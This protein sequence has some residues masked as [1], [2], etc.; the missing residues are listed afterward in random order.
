MLLMKILIKDYCKVLMKSCQNYRVQVLDP[1]HDAHGH[2]P[3]VCRRLGAGVQ[4]GAEALAYLLDAR[5]QLVSL[6]EYDE[7]RLVHLV[8]LRKKGCISLTFLRESEPNIGVLTSRT[9]V[10]KVR[11]DDLV[12]AGQSGNYLEAYV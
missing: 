6:E 12:K 1:G 8:R 2:L 10:H 11:T 7:H 3:P 5:L 4:R 9:S